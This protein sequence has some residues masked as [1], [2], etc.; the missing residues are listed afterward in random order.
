MINYTI[1]QE[2]TERERL[3]DLQNVKRTPR[4]P[5]K[6]PTKSKKNVFL[7]ETGN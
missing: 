2:E 1:G 7:K 6:V 3:P 4:D 5:Q